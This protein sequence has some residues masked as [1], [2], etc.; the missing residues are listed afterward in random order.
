[1]FDI[2]AL[3]DALEAHKI[4]AR[5]VIAET[6]G[7]TPREAG[8]EMLVWEGG[9]AGTIGGGRLELEAQTHALEMISEGPGTHLAR[10][11]LGPARN[12]CCGGAATL[13]T[14]VF[15]AAR[16]RAL[17][18]GFEYQGIWA[19]PIA[20]DAGPLSASARRKIEKVQHDDTP[21]PTTLTSGW[22]IEPVWRNRTPV[23]IYGA[24]HVGRALALVLIEL[25]QF[26]VFLVDVRESQFA[27][28]PDTLRQS[29]VSLPTEVMQSAPP[30]A[31]HLIMTPEHDYDLE[32]CH[33]LLQQEFA[34]AGLIGSDTKWARFRSRLSQLGHTAEQIER[35]QCPIGA[36][37]LGKHPQ[38]IAVGVT[39]DLMKH[40]NNQCFTQRIS[41]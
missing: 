7:S 12:Q 17:D 24:G 14:E 6:K 18:Q 10:I 39:A 34:F 27:G 32:L 38:A 37:E 25:P 35:I 36:P 30:E 33:T 1:M 11:A 23:Y 16:Y 5:I 31:M 26:E 22:L 8:T 28:L 4:V 21:I 2:E 3:S 41:A 19:R 40:K 9:S 29:W 13:V 15:D 20:P